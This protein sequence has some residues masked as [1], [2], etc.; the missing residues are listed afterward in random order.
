MSAELRKLAEAA[1][2]GEWEA[3]VEFGGGGRA[4]A[5]VA[6]WDEDA[7]WYDPDTSV[8]ATTDVGHDAD[9]A[10]IAA[11]SPDKVLELL[12]ENAALK[13]ENAALRA[14]LTATE[15][16]EYAAGGVALDTGEAER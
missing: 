7:G 2:R 14:G 3:A 4:I 1:T 10:Y 12:D 9:A 5:P 13:A 8:I 6:A 11:A 15:A 16:T